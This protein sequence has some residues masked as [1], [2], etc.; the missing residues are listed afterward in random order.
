M[1]EDRV[2]LFGKMCFNINANGEK[3]HSISSENSC[4]RM[5][6]LMVPSGGNWDSHN[7]RIWNHNRGNNLKNKIQNNLIKQ[8]FPKFSCKATM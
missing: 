6:A 2:T 8:G 7:A 3:I 4:Q 1:L 5:L